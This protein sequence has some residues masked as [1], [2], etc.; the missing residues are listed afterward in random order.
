MC[1]NFAA[2]QEDT[3]TDIYMWILLVLVVEYI[4]T[5]YRC[6]CLS[7]FPSPLN[8]HSGHGGAGTNRV[9]CLFIILSRNSMTQ[10]DI[11]YQQ[12]VKKDIDA[13]FLKP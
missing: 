2:I 10:G 13:V 4:N 1:A 9:F 6:S 11:L 7:S 12:L 5:N 3:T 8:P